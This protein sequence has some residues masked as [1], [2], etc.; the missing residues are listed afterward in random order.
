MK[1]S[2]PLTRWQ[3]ITLNCAC[4]TVCILVCS[5]PVRA[6]RKPQRYAL[7]VG[8]N[9]YT[10][11]KDLQFCGAD[12]QA[13]RD[14]LIAS[15]FPE[16]HVYHLHSQAKEARYQPFKA[17]IERQ[18][19]I[20]LGNANKEDIVVVAFSGHGVHTEGESY[21]CSSEA[22][23]DEPQGTM[24]SLN[25][26]YAR[27][28]RS[29][30]KFKLLLVDACRKDP[31]PEGQKSALS[32]DSNKELGIDIQE[33]PTGILSLTSCAE[34]QISM[35]DKKLGHGVFMHF[36][37]EGLAGEADREENGNKD[38]QVSLLELYEFANLK[39]KT[40]VA[41]RFNDFQTPKLTG[42]FTSTF[43]KFVIGT[44]TERHRKII[45]NSIGMKLVPIPAGE[46]MMGSGRSA[47]EIARLFKLKAEYFEDEH[48][49]HRVKITK[50]F[51]LGAH[52]VTVGQFREFIS[53]TAYKTDAEKDGEGGQGYD[54][55]TNNLKGRKPK[56]NWRS[57]GWSRTDAH[58][59][60]NV[61][62]N[63]AV[64]F[65]R[66]L[67]RSEGK[68]YRLPTE[69]EWEYAC[70]AGTGSLFSNGDDP[71][72]LTRVGN[73]ADATFKRKKMSRSYWGIEASDSVIF[74]APVGKYAPNA[75]GL[76]DMHGNVWEWCQ[77]WYGKDYYGQSP[78][79]DP[80]G[81]STGKTRV[82]RGG[83]WYS[84]PDYVRSE[85]RYGSAPDDRD[86]YIGFRLSRTP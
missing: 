1:H 42:E 59:V 66:W 4:L 79:E 65:C 28:K 44:T 80:P 48:P 62:W 41:R 36:L 5:D 35:E 6:Q 21:L 22:K 73:V 72:S 61:S 20:V 29:K 70:R 77:D 68:T 43:S 15:G 33:P 81:A 2:K 63:D 18:L 46:F 10:N 11:I 52:E 39:T 67:S 32:L 56:Y 7:L 76:Y 3:R 13:L 25:T 45:T 71:E 60:V 49:Q 75:F 78:L 17:N 34:G 83:S 47:A 57:T 27:L 16:E 8:V 19:E 40:Y 12:I 86:C 54:A 69:A 51:Y 38:G 23:L 53:A 74:S 24:V 82:L 14:Q 84:V 37:L 85:H 31:T 55:S 50:P 58:P 9:D 30:A 26:V 64:A